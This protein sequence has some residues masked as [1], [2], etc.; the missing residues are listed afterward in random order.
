MIKISKVSQELPGIIAAPR[1]FDVKV[2]TKAEMEGLM[3]ADSST[4]FFDGEKLL[5]G[6]LDNGARVTF[7]AR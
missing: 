7:W 2:L 5:K 3:G 6:A 4:D 1:E